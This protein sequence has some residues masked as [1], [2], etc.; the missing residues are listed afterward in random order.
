AICPK[1]ALQLMADAGIGILTGKGM[2]DIGRGRSSGRVGSD[3]TGWPE[4]LGPRQTA[5]VA[6][7]PHDRRARLAPGECGPGRR[8]DDGDDGEDDGACCPAVSQFREGRQPT[9][10]SQLFSEPVRV[11]RSW[12]A[13]GRRQLQHQVTCRWQRLQIRSSASSIIGSNVCRMER[14]AYVM[15]SK[16]V[17][18]AVETSKKLAEDYSS[19]I[20]T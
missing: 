1:F 6:H 14:Q 18:S 8:P 12:I 5:G 3:R 13:A 11:T 20:P 10:A 16:R 2:A 9:A 19:L 17:L 15:A 4:Q 7:G